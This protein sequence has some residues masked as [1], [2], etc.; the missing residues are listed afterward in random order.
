MQWKDVPRI[1]VEQTGYT[2]GE[3][4]WTAATFIF[5]YEGYT[6]E[7]DFEIMARRCR[8]TAKT[9]SY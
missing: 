4:S 9:R 8:H 3:R 6:E 7:W 1:S 2:F 5:L